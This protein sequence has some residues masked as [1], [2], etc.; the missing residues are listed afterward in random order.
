[1]LNMGF[2]DKFVKWV[3]FYITTVEYS[4]CFNGT[5]VGPTYPKRGLRHG[6]PLSPYLFLLCVEGLSKSLRNVEAAGRIHGCKI[7]DGAPAISYLLFTDDN[8][9]FFRA[10]REEVTCIKTVL[11]S[12]ESLS[13][14]AVNYQKSG[15]FFSAN[16]RRDK[17]QEIS[18]I[19]GVYT[20]PKQVFWVALFNK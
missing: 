3:M 14:Q 12:Y 10:S 7:G 15:I 9:L 17:H 19:L 18:S 16:V 8:F 6:D 5:S 1:M 11:N 20:E 2:A 13:G 4:I